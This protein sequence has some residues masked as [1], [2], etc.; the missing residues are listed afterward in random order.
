M[1]AGTP[2]SFS[3]CTSPNTP[4]SPKKGVATSI[5]VS[6]TLSECDYLD[7]SGF[8]TLAVKP[9]ASVTQITVYASETPTGTYVIVDSLGASGVIT[10]VAS[11]WNVI[12]PAKI[13]PFSYVQ[14][15][16]NQTV[17]NASVLAST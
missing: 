12:D 10:V 15:L 7:I 2:K 16:S 5:A 9:P 13:A 3:T 14:L 4:S 11:K 8:R 1:A 6:S 17:A